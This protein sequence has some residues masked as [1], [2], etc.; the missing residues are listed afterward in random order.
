MPFNLQVKGV[1][2]IRFHM[3]FYVITHMM[4]DTQRMQVNKIIENISLKCLYYSCLDI[5]HC[6]SQLSLIIAIKLI[7]YTF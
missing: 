4:C 1:L 7:N 5:R 2:M 3:C 6:C